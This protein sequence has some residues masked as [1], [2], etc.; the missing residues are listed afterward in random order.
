L[1]SRSWTNS[2]TSTSHVTPGHPRCGVHCSC[3]PHRTA[4]EA[5]FRWSRPRIRRTVGG[6]PSFRWALSVFGPGRHVQGSGR[7]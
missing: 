2:D 6:L 5:L 1:W 4:S 3:S 7:S